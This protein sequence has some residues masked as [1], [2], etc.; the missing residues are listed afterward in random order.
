MRTFPKLLAKIKQFLR[1]KLLEQE[2]QKVAIVKISL[3]FF[4]GRHLTSVS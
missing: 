1:G 4:R 3:I 2:V